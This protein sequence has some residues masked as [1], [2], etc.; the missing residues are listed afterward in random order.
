MNLRYDS[1]DSFIK[2]FNNSNNEEEFN[3]V[4]RIIVIVY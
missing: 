1:F 4:I 3:Q 2:D